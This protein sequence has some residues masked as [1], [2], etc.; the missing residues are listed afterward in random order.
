MSSNNGYSLKVK[1]KAT[2]LMITCRS[3]NVAQ[4]WFPDLLISQR[5]NFHLLILTVNYFA[6]PA[7][8]QNIDPGSHAVAN[9]LHQHTHRGVCSDQHGCARGGTKISS[10]EGTRP[11]S[12]SSSPTLLQQQWQCSHLLAPPPRRYSARRPQR[13]AASSKERECPGQDLSAFPGEAS[14]EG[15]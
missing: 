3:K 1:W 4:Y 11:G 7:G 8:R 12:W 13:A 10:Q 14:R 15:P 9:R 6:L 5:I 2:L